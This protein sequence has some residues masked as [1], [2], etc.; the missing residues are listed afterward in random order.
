MMRKL[1]LFLVLIAFVASSSSKIPKQM[2]EE[3]KQLLKDS[4][5]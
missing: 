2:T 1:L 5:L 3:Q 4:Q